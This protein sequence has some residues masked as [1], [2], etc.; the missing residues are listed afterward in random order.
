M[1]FSV[2]I[3][4]A[5]ILLSACQKESVAPNNN[6]ACVTIH[7]TIRTHDTIYIQP[8]TRLQILTAKVWQLDEL[9]KNI[10]GINSRYIRNG[11]NTTGTSYNLTRFK[12]ET[13][14]TGSYIDET[15]V[16]H[17]LNWTFAGTDQKSIILNIGAP[18]AGSFVWYTVEL[19]GNYLHQT[20]VSGSSSLLSSRLVQTP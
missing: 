15:G 4:S 13:D 20:S 12:F 14:G 8:P 6:T 17:T 18:S 2:P 3:L 19:A 5:V 1:F 10:S 16:S 9:N 7:D 11:T